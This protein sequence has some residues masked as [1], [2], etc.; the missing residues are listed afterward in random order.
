MDCQLTANEW[1]IR[2]IFPKLWENLGRGMKGGTVLSGL[3]RENILK[4][5]FSFQGH[6]WGLYIHL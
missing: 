5:S 6:K 1:E 2:R 3:Y 4:M